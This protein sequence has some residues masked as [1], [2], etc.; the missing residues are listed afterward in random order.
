MWTDEED[1]IFN[2]IAQLADKMEQ[3]YGLPAIDAIEWVNDMQEWC[4][5][6]TDPI[7]DED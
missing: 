1:E 7:E 3:V 4:N 6:I 2:L 5:A